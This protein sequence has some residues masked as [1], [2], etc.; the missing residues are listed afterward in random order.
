MLPWRSVRLDQV[1]HPTL[2]VELVASLAKR[3]E[4]DDPWAEF[5]GG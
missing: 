4:R 1:P 5:A 3:L 2:F